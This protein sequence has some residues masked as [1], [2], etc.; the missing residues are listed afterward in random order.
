MIT[1]QLN[2]LQATGQPPAETISLLRL[3]IPG[4][5]SNGN[6][7]S[8]V[9]RFGKKDRKKKKTTPSP[10][11]ETTRRV[12]F[13]GRN[14]MPMD[15]WHQKRQRDDRRDKQK[16]LYGAAK[17]KN[18]PRPQTRKSADAAACIGKGESSCTNG[19]GPTIVDAPR[20]GKGDK[21][22]KESPKC[23]NCNLGLG[24]KRHAHWHWIKNKGTGEHNEAKARILRKKPKPAKKCDHNPSEHDGSPCPNLAQHCHP[25]NDKAKGIKAFYRAHS[26]VPADHT[27][28]EADST[29][30]HPDDI[31]DETPVHA[32]NGP[33]PESKHDEVETLY[34]K[35]MD[36]NVSATDMMS[37]RETEQ[38]AATTAVSEAVFA[39]A[40]HEVPATQSD[41]EVKNS[42]YSSD[43]TTTAACTATPP[44]TTPAAEM[45]FSFITRPRYPP[46]SFSVF[47]P[48]LTL[49]TL[50]IPPSPPTPPSSTVGTTAL[51]K[52]SNLLLSD[53]TARPVIPTD[54]EV[55]AVELTTIFY[56]A[57]GVNEKRSR[58]VN[59]FVQDAAFSLRSYVSTVD[60]DHVFV[61]KEQISSSDPIS[62]RYVRKVNFPWSGDV[63]GQK[64]SERAVTEEVNLY[65]GI[66]T[67]SRKVFIYTHLWQLL[68]A[69][70]TLLSKVPM[71]EDG[72][73]RG[74]YTTRLKKKIADEWPL[75]YDK[76]VH[77][78]DSKWKFEHT[79]ARFMNHAVLVTKFNQQYGSSNAKRQDRLMLNGSKGRSSM[80]PKSKHP[81]A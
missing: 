26:T 57:D 18:K 79:L 29:S 5:K 69:D 58:T 52:I 55:M 74:T 35:I 70:K 22:Q 21:K 33:L 43:T 8:P 45:T 80:S 10:V 30:H 56:N 24:C 49:P 39:L 38:L 11:P 59:E 48:F 65:E 25:D 34:M 20:V 66:Y 54:E 46:Q 6:T 68:L 81:T 71:D 73:L 27:T 23:S 51:Q 12:N 75:F 61:E 13:V 76:W 32:L 28:D 53:D 37:S 16:R 77:D 41:R 67:R 31:R 2:E 64:I 7:A 44:L 14:D 72:K 42:S 40:N 19:D 62:K 47:S 4:N 36:V 15:N 60:C 78:V 63:L 9:R 50:T 3:P 1:T 17:Q